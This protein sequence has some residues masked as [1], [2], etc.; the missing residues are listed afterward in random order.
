M[1]AKQRAQPINETSESRILK[2]L[3][4]SNNRSNVLTV[5]G[6]STARYQKKQP[7]G[8]REVR[9]VLGFLLR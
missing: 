3:G 9:T 8:H 2:E 4:K 1:H 5:N 7:M 6:S